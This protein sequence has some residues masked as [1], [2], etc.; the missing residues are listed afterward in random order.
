MPPNIEEDCVGDDGQQYSVCLR[1][2][3]ASV[4]RDLEI[5]AAPARIE[6]TVILGSAWVTLRPQYLVTE[7]TK[8]IFADTLLV[9]GTLSVAGRASTFVEL[10]F[11]VANAARE[12][13]RLLD[14]E[15]T[16]R[17]Q[18]FVFVILCI[19]L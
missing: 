13:V 16:N 12:A 3:I 18:S 17:V 14:C 9:V 10:S 2:G 1:G 15:A 11:E 8:V 6:R 5:G 4:K 19:A 7:R